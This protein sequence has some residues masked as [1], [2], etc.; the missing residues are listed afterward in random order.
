V[1]KKIDC[2]MVKVEDLDQAREFYR[3]RLGLVELW[4]DDSEPAIG[5][6]FP[7]SDAEIVLHRMDL[8]ARIDVHYLVDDVDGSVD[9]LREQGVHIVQGPFDIPIGRCAVLLDP[10][11]NTVSILDVSKGRR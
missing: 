4:R 11:G 5:M 6:G 8:P 2:V 10:F 1:L 3:D 7:E 9:E